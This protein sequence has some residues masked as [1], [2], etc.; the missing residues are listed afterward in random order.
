ML[1]SFEESL[2]H[3]VKPYRSLVVSKGRFRALYY[4][5]NEI[6]Y[7]AGIWNCK[8]DPKKMKSLYD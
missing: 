3:R 6:I 1:G 4:T 8:Q 5:E 2:K 7:I